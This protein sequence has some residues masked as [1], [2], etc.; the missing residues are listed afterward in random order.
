MYQVDRN[1]LP[2]DLHHDTGL[3]DYSRVT[4][5]RML[6]HMDLNA[7]VRVNVR[8]YRVSQKKWW[9]DFTRKTIHIV[10]IKGSKMPRKILPP[11]F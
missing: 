5:H 9:Q 1:T 11:F 10:S 6:V 8:L 4:H 3:R 2:C 7:R